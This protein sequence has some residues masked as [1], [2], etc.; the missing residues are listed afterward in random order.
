M[1]AKAMCPN[2]GAKY[3][4]PSHIC[5]PMKADREHR[6]QAALAKLTQKLSLLR[7]NARP[8]PRHSVGHD[9]RR[10]SRLSDVARSLDEGRVARE[11]ALADPDDAQRGLVGR[12]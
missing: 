3:R 9:R 7:S 8:K 2:C 1:P 10:P 6:R 4:G 11:Q 12:D 5:D